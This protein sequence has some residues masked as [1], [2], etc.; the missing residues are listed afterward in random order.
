MAIKSKKTEKSKVKA[1]ESEKVITWQKEHLWK[2]VKKKSSKNAK[3]KPTERQEKV[4]NILSE[5]MVEN[6]G[7]SSKK[8]I[9]AESGYSESVQKNPA[10]VFEAASMQKALKSAGLDIKSLKMKHKQLLN[11]W[12]LQS[13]NAHISIPPDAFTDMVIKNIP[14]SRFLHFFDDPLNAQ[15]YYYFIFPDTITQTKALEMQY[16]ILGEFAPEKHR[17]VDKDNND[18]TIFIPDNGRN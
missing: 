13:I 5:K 17:L 15:R 1:S 2:E 9:L 3:R 7:F 4:L 6:G 12:R 18:V 11:M 16:K 10:K 14:G 8:S